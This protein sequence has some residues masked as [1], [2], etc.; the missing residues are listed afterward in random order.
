MGKNNLL[1]LRSLSYKK[2]FNPEVVALFF[3]VMGKDIA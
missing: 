2:I 1:T 3:S